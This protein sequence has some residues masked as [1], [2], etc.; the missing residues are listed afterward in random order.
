MLRTK[1]LSKTL[2]ALT[3]CALTSTLSAQFVGIRIGDVD[4]FGF[5]TAA[6][7][8]AANGGPA[9][10]NFGGP[11]TDQDFLPDINTN[12]NVATGSGDDFDNRNN[13][14]FSAVGAII[15]SGT[16]GA[17]FTDIALSTSYDKSSAAG[18]VLTYDPFTGTSS[19]GSGG[20]FP[21]DGNPATLSNQPGFV[22]DFRVAETDILDGTDIFFN[23]LF[24]D[25]DVSPASVQ[26]NFASTPSQTLGV[27]AQS[28]NADGLIQNAFV[29]LD[30]N[31]VFAPAVGGYY[32]GYVE[33]NFLAPNEP[34]TA[35]DFVELSV[36][37]IPEPATNALIAFLGL[38][39]FIWYRRRRK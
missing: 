24:G 5:G 16:T 30:F 3:A 39:A 36:T 27:S 18:T 17:E 20:A 7:F 1:S 10:V 29:A 28:G 14:G 6:G 32:N 22:F 21:G 26:F 34:Y 25:Y 38:G 2:L 9:N 15:D 23:M 12:G 8:N 11:L 13:E 33:V 37:P 19:T 4:G 35:F 31:D